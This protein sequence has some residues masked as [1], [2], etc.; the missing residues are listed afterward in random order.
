MAVQQK[1]K[2]TFTAAC[3]LGV[4]GYAFLIGGMYTYTYFAGE[5]LLSPTIYVSIGIL[6]LTRQYRLLQ[7]LRFK[8]RLL[9]LLIVV[10]IGLYCSFSINTNIYIVAIVNGCAI[11]SCVLINRKKINKAYT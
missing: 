1:K 2:D 7:H 6:L 9:E 11:G 8:D 5:T 10:A 3:H 4:W